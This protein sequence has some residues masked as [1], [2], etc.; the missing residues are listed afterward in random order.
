AVQHGHLSADVWWNLLEHA[1]PFSELKEEEAT[2][3][4]QHMLDQQILSESDH[5][6][7]LGVEGERIYGRANFRKLY[8][9]F[10]VP[11]L[12]TVL[13]GN[14]EI[15]QVDSSFLASL[16]EDDDLG[17]F[18]LG[19]RNWTIVN[20]DWERAKCVVKPWQ[21]G[22][23]ARWAGTPRHLSWEVCQEMRALLVSDD[24]S[25]RWSNRAKEVM[26]DLRARYEFLREGDPFLNAGTEKIIWH[27]FA[28]GAANVLLARMLEH[29]LGGRLVSRNTS[30]SF[31][32]KA[33]ES[34]VAVKQAVDD[35]RQSN[36]PTR[37]DALR[38]A[39]DISNSRISKFQP[40]LPNQLGRDVLLE[41]IVDARGARL[42]L[43]GQR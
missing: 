33:G 43:K 12:V 13:H 32:E 23:P 42:A 5:H 14:Q 40:C 26:R 27:N 29:E 35:L 21:G 22:K 15:G 28:G 37:E 41:K 17:S 10:D 3:V 25:P 18:T 2:A 9:V 1:A 11:R 6:L 38:F 31:T 24:V 7:W 4:L 39:P 8:S 36:R 16:E 19:G 30:I 34:M 20:I